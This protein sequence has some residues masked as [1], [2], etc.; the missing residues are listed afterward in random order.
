M[1]RAQRSR[2]WS[3]WWV[4]VAGIALIVLSAGLY[5]PAPFPELRQIDLTVLNEASDG[6]CEVRW[7]DPYAPRD[8]AGVYQCDPDRDAVL[9]APAYDPETG[10]GWDSGWVLAEGDRKGELYSLDEHD[11]TG[12]DVSEALFGAGLLVTYVGLL[13]AGVPVRLRWPGGG[14]SAKE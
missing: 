7:R 2:W 6:R 14:A 5:E 4:L 3:R 1:A 9:K 8:R 10:F 12:S 13:A 11:D